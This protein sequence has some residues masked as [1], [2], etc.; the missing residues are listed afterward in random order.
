MQNAVENSNRKCFQKILSVYYSISKTLGKT[1]INSQQVSRMWPLLFSWYIV[2]LRL[3]NELSRAPS[4]SET[5]TS[6]CLLSSEMQKYYH[7]TIILQKP[8]HL[9]ELYNKRYLTKQTQF[10]CLRLVTRYFNTSTLVITLKTGKVNI[11]SVSY[12]IYYK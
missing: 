5:R 11:V 4:T 10:Q 3:A 2:N 9:L 7:N 6:L 1:K 8:V 12:H